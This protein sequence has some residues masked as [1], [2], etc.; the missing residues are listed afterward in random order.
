MVSVCAPESY[1]RPVCRARRIFFAAYLRR[2]EISRSASSSQ[3]GSFIRNFTLHKHS[4]VY[5]SLLFLA[6][7]KR[8]VGSNDPPAFSICFKAPLLAPCNFTVNFL[9]SLPLATILTL[10]CGSSIKPASAKASVSTVDF[11]R[12]FSCPV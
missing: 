5:Y 11:L 2:P 12:S 1:K 9:S 3:A 7:P 8:G 4:L 10:V 6:R